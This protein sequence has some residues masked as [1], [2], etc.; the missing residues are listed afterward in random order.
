[1]FFKIL[2][3]FFSIYYT[4][5]IFCVG[6]GIFSNNWLIFDILTD[7]CE[8]LENWWMVMDIVGKI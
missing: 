4:Y 1:M 7:A 8:G 6:L 2:I 5:I 3:V